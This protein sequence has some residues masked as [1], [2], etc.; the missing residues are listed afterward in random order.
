MTAFRMA[1]QGSV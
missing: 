1:T